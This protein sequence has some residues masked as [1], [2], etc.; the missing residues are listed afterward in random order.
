M[1]KNSNSDSKNSKQGQIGFYIVLALCTIMIG[2]SCWFAYT[3]TSEDLTIQLESALDSTKD[4]AAAELQTDVTKP[5][6]VPPGTTDEAACVPSVST[7]AVFRPS[8]DA[9]VNTQSETTEQTQTETVANVSTAKPPA[10]PVDGEIIGAYSNG[11][12]VKSSTTGVWQTH[13]GID[14]ACTLGDEVRAM[15][16]GIVDAVEEDPLWGVCVTIDHQN[17]IF[18]RYCSLNSGL[19]VNIG[20]KVTTGTVIGAAGN[21]ADLESSMDTH[22]H[23]EVLQGETY[24]DPVVYIEGE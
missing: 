7:E 8:T 15:D 19:N 13:N 14:I 24:I 10:Y 3:Q 18:S 23:F 16:T 9:S 22:I 11:E 4:M 1:N 12:L 20:D 21:T 2:V 5:E 6:T 17:G